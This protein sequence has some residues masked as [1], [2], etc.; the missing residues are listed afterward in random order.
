MTPWPCSASITILVLLGGLGQFFCPGLGEIFYLVPV[1][2]VPAGGVQLWRLW[3]GH[4]VQP[5]SFIFVLLSA[6]VISLFCIEVEARRGS[7]YLFKS[8]LIF[9]AAISLAWSL[10]Q[11]GVDQLGFLAG[12]KTAL[13]GFPLA[14]F[15]IAS[16]L[17][18]RP[19]DRLQGTGYRL[20]VLFVASVYLSTM[21]Y[22]QWRE[23]TWTIVLPAHMFAI[24][25][26]IA[27]EAWTRRAEE[28]LVSRFTGL[29]DP[30]EILGRLE[31]DET[32][33]DR[34]DVILAR[35]AVS[36]LDGLSWDDWS[37]LRQT[38]RRWQKRAPSSPDPYP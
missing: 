7:A 6:G 5:E 1:S 25:L 38:S 30:S 29:A 31:D 3:T 8:C 17:L 16:R 18:V 4:F 9:G 26:A 21:L 32:T 22:L 37:F 2:L 13:A 27:Q 12:T 10:L 33:R 23:R 19:L 11:L 28:R 35:V 36:G 20:S 34:V 15:W 24:L 14:T